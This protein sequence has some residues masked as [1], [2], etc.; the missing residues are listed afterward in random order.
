MRCPSRSTAV[1]N[2]LSVP[3]VV[4]Q[5]IVHGSK[6]KQYS[7]KLQDKSFF[8]NTVDHDHLPSRSTFKNFQLSHYP[9]NTELNTARPAREQHST[10]PFDDVDVPRSEHTHTH[11]SYLF[12]PFYGRVV[13]WT[14]FRQKGSRIRIP[15]AVEVVDVVVGPHSVPC[16]IDNYVPAVIFLC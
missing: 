13:I 1:N 9:R 15:V 6:H 7:T 5:N 4:R 8:Y 3:C 10:P 2:A 16:T 14:I 11:I 12:L